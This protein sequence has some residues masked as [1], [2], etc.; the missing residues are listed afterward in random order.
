VNEAEKRKEEGMATAAGTLS[1]SIHLPEIRALAHEIGRAYGVCSI[2]DVRAYCD[3]R[4]IDYEILGN[5]AGSIFKDGSWE[6]IKYVKARHPKG[7]AHIVMLW[8]YR[9]GEGT[10][11]R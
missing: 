2:N 10:S 9:G 11:E 1:A 6:P 8:K 7:Q 3:G 5:S 4:G